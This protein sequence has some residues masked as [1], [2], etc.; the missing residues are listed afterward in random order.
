[1]SN[2]FQFRTVSLGIFPLHKHEEQLLLVL[3]P[4]KIE[5][6]KERKTY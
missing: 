5:T 3:S 4:S 1:M 2:D 6:N